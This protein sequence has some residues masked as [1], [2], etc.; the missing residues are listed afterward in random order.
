M[1]NFHVRDIKVRGK[2]GKI[3]KPQS[4]KDLKL[5]AFKPYGLYIFPNDP[6]L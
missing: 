4:F 3:L 6:A 1:S 5:K 2:F